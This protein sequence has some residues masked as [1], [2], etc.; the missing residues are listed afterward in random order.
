MCHGEKLVVYGHSGNPDNIHFDSQPWWGR[1]EIGSPQL[2]DFFQPW[3]W[4]PA[5]KVFEMIFSSKLL[6][7]AS[8]KN[9]NPPSGYGLENFR[10]GKPHMN[11]VIVGKKALHVTMPSDLRIGETHQPNHNPLQEPQNNQANLY[12]WY[13]V[14]RNQ[15]FWILQV[16]LQVQVSF[17]NGFS[18]FLLFHFWCSNSPALYVDEALVNLE[19]MAGRPASH[20]RMSREQGGFANGDVCTA[21]LRE[22]SWV[23]LRE[24]PN[25]HQV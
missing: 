9:R 13:S 1:L 21:A 11:W 17:W 23:S 14:S 24:P 25:Y 4:L 19:V 8:P 18:I 2:L 7:F 22:V 15:D 12:R 16:S 5:T 10:S 6:R 3:S 20:L